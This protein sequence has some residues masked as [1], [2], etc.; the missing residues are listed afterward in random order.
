VQ[1]KW[2]ALTYKKCQAT[3]KAVRDIL[4]VGFSWFK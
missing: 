1:R 4:I 2:M 3:T